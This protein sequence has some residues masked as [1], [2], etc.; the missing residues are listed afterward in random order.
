MVGLPFLTSAFSLPAG[1]SLDHPQP[2]YD[3]RSR[4]RNAA[5]SP[6][7]VAQ[8]DRATDFGSVG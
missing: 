7:P 2:Q 1:P 6:A 8:L 3:T 5:I 4:G